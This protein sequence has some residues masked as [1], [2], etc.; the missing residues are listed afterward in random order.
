MTVPGVGGK[1]LRFETPEDLKK[2]I[3]DYF[4]YVDGYNKA[5]KDGEK[6]K[7]YTMSGICVFLGIAKETFWEYAK[8]SGYADSIKEAKARVEACIEEGSLSGK[9]NTIGAIFN[10]KNNF[11]WVDKFD[12]AT[13]SQPEQLTPDDIRNQLA[14]RRKN[15]ESDDGRE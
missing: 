3:D 1:P 8:K 15:G 4:N 13:T 7:P 5:L 11:G 14:Q 10:L 9:W 6:P 2:G 12:F